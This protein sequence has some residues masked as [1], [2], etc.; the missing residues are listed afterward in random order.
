MSPHTEVLKECEHHHK[1]CCVKC[2]SWSAIITG[3][4]VAI[5][6]GFLMNLFGIAIGLSAFKTTPEGVKTLA[7]G[8]Y[9]GLLIGTIIIMFVAGW[10]SGYLGRANCLNR[11]MG[12]LYGFTTWSLALIM[13]V[14]LASQL[15]NFT[16]T[17]VLDYSSS[18]T[19]YNVKGTNHPEAP[20][21]TQERHAETNAPS[22]KVVVNEQKAVNLIGL[23]L[24]LTFVLFFA[25]A[26]AACF[27]G[28]F[29][30]CRCK[31]EKI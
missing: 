8:G 4:L 19:Q 21:V 14:L 5:G 18:Y 23:S 15:S 30:L 10:V 26:L 6:L 16:T 29:G 20:L 28:Y 13:T 31:S 12:A 3:A 11:D 25:G 1:F 24:L 9:F 27:G 22:N 7:I 2:I 17:N